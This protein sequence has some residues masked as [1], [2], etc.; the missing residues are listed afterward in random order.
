MSTSATFE[1]DSCLKRFRCKN[2]VDQHM[3]DKVHHKNKNENG[4]DNKPR[5]LDWVFA[6]LS[7]VQ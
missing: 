1:C 4:N 6:N 3:R 7:D 5:C 2:A